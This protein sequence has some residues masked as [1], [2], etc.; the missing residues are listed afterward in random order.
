[1]DFR[2]IKSKDLAEYIG[3]TKSSMS[4]FLNGKR[5][6]GQEKLEAMLDYLKIKLV[7]EEELNNK[8]LEGKSSQS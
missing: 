1:M 5:A 4:L 8:Q 7:R 6:M 3:V 2:K